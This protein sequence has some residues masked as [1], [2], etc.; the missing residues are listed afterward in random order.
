MQNFAVKRILKVA[1]AGLKLQ[2][3]Q[4]AHG[5]LKFRFG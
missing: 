2:K 4:G 1:L 5:N 3:L